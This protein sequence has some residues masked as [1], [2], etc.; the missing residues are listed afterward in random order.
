PGF[1]L[2][3]LEVFDF[4]EVVINCTRRSTSTTPLQSLAL[5][6]SEFMSE[7]AGHL[8][9]RVRSLS[10][11]DAPDD[12]HIETAFQLPLCRKATATELESCREH[13]RAQTALYLTEKQTSDQAAQHALAS[14]CL[15]LLASNE[16]LYIG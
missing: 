4:P 10:G 13:L 15:M 2:S 1:V 14:L 16:F 9:D 12:R 8:A 7:Q 11:T 6:N 5:V 3:M